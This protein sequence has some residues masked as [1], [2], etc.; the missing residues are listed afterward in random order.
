MPSGG[1][2]PDHDN[3][4]EWFDAGAFCVGM[5]SQLITRDI[6]SRG[7]YSRLEETVRLS[8]EI[9]KKLRA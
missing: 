1:V 2:S 4:K 7:D 3:L 8:M 9:I 5:G 6:I